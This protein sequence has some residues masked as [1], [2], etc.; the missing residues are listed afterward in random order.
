[1]AHAMSVSA[2]DSEAILAA[3]HALLHS[4]L[5][6]V[7]ICDSEAFLVHVALHALSRSCLE[8][9]QLITQTLS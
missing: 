8:V 2:G 7:S 1:M 9:F 6:N 4:C 5:A 3:L